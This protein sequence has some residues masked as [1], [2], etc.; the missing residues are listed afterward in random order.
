[1]QHKLLDIGGDW[2]RMQLPVL[3]QPGCVQCCWQGL[4]AW[5]EFQ[6]AQP[7]HVKRSW[8]CKGTLE[9]GT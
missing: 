2:V 7:K 6:G 1:V 9:Q 3:H 4:P 5:Q 8:S